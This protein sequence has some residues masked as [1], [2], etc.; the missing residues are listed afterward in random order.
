[1]KKILHLVL[2]IVLFVALSYAIE[3]IRITM[4]FYPILLNIAPD[5]DISFG[6]HRNFLTHSIAIPIVILA[7]NWDVFNILCVLAFAFHC[8]CD[9]SLRP[10]KWK[11]Y[12]TIKFYHHTI[13]FGAE[14]KAA[15]AMT[16]L[17]L[18]VQGILGILLFIFYWMFWI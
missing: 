15:G 2:G 16:S 4:I 1:M 11:G 17:W 18:V 3:E 8:L 14:D 5:I 10:S 13:F 7:F 12:Y 6:S 9:V